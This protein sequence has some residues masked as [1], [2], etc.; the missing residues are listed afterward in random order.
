MLDVRGLLVQDVN[1]LPAFL[2]EMLPSYPELLCSD[3]D[4]CT[5]ARLRIRVCY[6]LVRIPPDTGP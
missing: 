2:G 1:R 4:F 5:W 3:P 6:V